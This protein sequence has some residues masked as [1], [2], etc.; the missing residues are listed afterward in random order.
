MEND[1]LYSPDPEYMSIQAL[2]GSGQIAWPKPPSPDFG[3]VC[4]RCDR[5]NV[6]KRWT[7]RSVIKCKC[8]CYFKWTHGEGWAWYPGEEKDG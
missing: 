6:R 3:L 8:G 7:I 5:V 1:D 4:H 2:S